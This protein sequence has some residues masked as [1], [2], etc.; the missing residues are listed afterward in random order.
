MMST[1]SKPGRR[2]FFAG[3]GAV[4]AAGIAAKMASNPPD[5]SPPAEPEPPPGS[6]YR[7]TEHIQKYYRTT[8]I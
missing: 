4:A 7:L 5:S 8:K 6:G 1:Q 3:M 2:T